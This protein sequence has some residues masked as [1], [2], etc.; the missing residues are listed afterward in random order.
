MKSE[1]EGDGE[2]KDHEYRECKDGHLRCLKCN[3]SPREPEKCQKHGYD[4]AKMLREPEGEIDGAL[5]HCQPIL[6]QSIFPDPIIVCY[7]KLNG[8]G[9]LRGDREYMWQAIKKYCESR[10]EQDEN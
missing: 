4:P 7:E 2:C 5:K 1:P 3:Q 8:K 6:K 10:G 9:P